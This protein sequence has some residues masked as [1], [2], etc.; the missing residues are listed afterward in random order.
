MARTVWSLIEKSAVFARMEEVFRQY[1]NTTRKEALRQAQSVL[2]SHRWVVI[3][4][5]RVFNYK[6]RIDISKEFIILFHQ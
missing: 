2:K 3:T 4:D 6:D 1:P 5:Q